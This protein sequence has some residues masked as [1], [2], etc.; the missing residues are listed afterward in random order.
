MH[1]IAVSAIVANP[2][3]LATRTVSP[4]K[5]L[6]FQASSPKN[7]PGRFWRPLFL[8]GRSRH[9]VSSAPSYRTFAYSDRLLTSMLMGVGVIQSAPRMGYGP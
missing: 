8:P 2:F 7:F 9:S 1:A 5:D 4:Q 6:A 3:A